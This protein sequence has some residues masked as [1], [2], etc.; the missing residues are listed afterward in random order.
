MEK[1]DLKDRK[2]LY[3]LS[4]DGR[5]SFRS[6]GRKVGLSKDI[7]ANRVKKLQENGVILQ[8]CTIFDYL[9]LN[10][11]PFRFYFKYQYI[12]PQ[13]KKEI[14]NHF[15]N[16]EYSTVVCSTEGSYDLIVLILIKNVMDIYPFWQKTLDK[17]GDY[18]ADRVFSIYMGESIYG[19]SCLSDEKDGRKKPIIKRDWVR[20]EHDDLDIKIL[21]IL[22]VNSRI[23][24]LEIAEKLNT[25]T[26]TINNRIKK[27]I[28]LGVILGYTIMP[29]MSKIGYQGFKVDFYLREHNEIHQII[30][31]VE[32]NPNLFSVDYTLG[33]ADLELEFWLKNVNQ[34][35]QIIE[36]LSNKFPKLI[37]N[38]KYFY[39]VKMHKILIL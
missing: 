27:L 36:D 7:V 19:Y 31:Y 21:K 22:V 29:N 28:K 17:F 35:H 3:Q 20:V 10:L 30:K 25:N 15:V 13:I 6:V 24:T 37:R 11:I 34:L 38:Y 8:F 9:K 12:T 5:Q 32:K 39:I 18:F 16:Y 33:H 26:S 4:L 23:P 1:L 14:I 2:I